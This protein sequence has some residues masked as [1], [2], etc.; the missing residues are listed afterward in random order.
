LLAVGALAA[1]AAPTLTGNV[2]GTIGMD[3]STGV[4]TLDTAIMAQA[5][6]DEA[7]TLAATLTVDE[8]G[9]QTLATTAAF[10]LDALALSGSA[11]F[12]VPTSSFTDAAFALTAPLLDA[13]L[14]VSAVVEPGAIGVQMT[15]TA[16]GDSVIQS[17]TVGFNLDAFGRIQTTSCT[18]PFTQ[19]EARFSLPL[20][21]C[22]TAIDARI[23]FDC[24]GLGELSLSAPHVGDL[25]F[26][27][28]LSSFLTFTTDEKTITLSPSLNLENPDC[29]DFYAG[30]EWDAAT[31]TLSELLIYGF[32]VRCDIGE[33]QLRMLVALDPSV[34]ALVKSPYRSLLGL[35]W[36][37]AGCCGSDGEASLVFFFGSANL[38][39][40]EEIDA[41]LS[42]PITNQLTLSL[43]IEYPMTGLP[44]ISFGWQ[45]M[46]V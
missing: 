36:P 29:F 26:A 2:D 16:T 25:P 27:I 17:L 42:F 43:A 24:A 37:L 31:H 44:I 33:I 10:T 5:S 13:D 23:R 11:T 22:D 28:S 46:L 32:G 21:A 41:E 8:L 39:D 35:I 45:I 9:A 6:W 20:D 7:A 30:L 38:F 1:A 4:I 34:L 18:L 15:L 14:T 3:T 12:D 19:A 40:L